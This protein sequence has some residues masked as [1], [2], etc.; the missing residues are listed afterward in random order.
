MLGDGSDLHVTVTDSE[1]GV[2]AYLG[3]AI[4][5]DG[6]SRRPGDD[7]PPWAS[8]SRRPAR[9][10]GRATGTPPSP[11]YSHVSDDEVRDFWQRL[12]SRDTTSPS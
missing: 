6:V 2:P 7:G 12:T 8:A 10:R 3:E 1:V 11:A 5:R 9:R 4:F